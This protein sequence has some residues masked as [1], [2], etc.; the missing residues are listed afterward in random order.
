MIDY[1]YHPCFYDRAAYH[2]R[3]AALIEPWGWELYSYVVMPQPREQGDW[4]P[5]YKLVEKPR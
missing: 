4:Q 1:I 2:P 5:D 3:I